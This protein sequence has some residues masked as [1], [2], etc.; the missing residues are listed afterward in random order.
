VKSAP[1]NKEKVPRLTVAAIKA[2]LRRGAKGADELHE[3]L[4]RS[5][6][7]GYSRSMSLRLR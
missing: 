6:L 4:E 2:A 3:A 5:H 7:E 1:R